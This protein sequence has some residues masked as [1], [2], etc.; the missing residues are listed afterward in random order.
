[1][2][3]MHSS[4]CAVT[5][6]GIIIE[7]QGWVELGHLLFSLTKKPSDQLVCCRLGP[8]RPFWAFKL[9]FLKNTRLLTTKPTLHSLPISVTQSP[10]HPFS[11]VFVTH[12]A[13][14]CTLP[15]PPTAC[16]SVLPVV[17]LHTS[18]R[19]LHQP[20]P[21]KPM[22]NK[23]PNILGTH[24]LLS[25]PVGDLRCNCHKNALRSRT[26]SHTSH[27]AEACSTSLASAA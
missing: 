10:V 19:L 15:S 7:R 12:H 14:A 2:E 6:W 1:M 17:S 23:K 13:P 5:S 9:I 24:W 4:D 21:R 16:P 25:L 20:S 8:S 11:P 18:Q 27:R 26:R 22:E 3:A